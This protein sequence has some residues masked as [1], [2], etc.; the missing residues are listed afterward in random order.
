MNAEIKQCRNCVSAYDKLVDF[1]NGGEVEEMPD[2]IAFCIK[3][4]VKVPVEWDGCEDGFEAIVVEPASRQKEWKE[5]SLAGYVNHVFKPDG[6]VFCAKRRVKIPAEWDGCEDGFE[7]IEAKETSGTDH[8]QTACRVLRELKD[9]IY[10]QRANDMSE[11]EFVE[12]LYQKITSF[13][14][15]SLTTD[16][17]QIC[18][19]LA[20][21]NQELEARVKDLDQS[22]TVAHEANH[23]LRIDNQYLKST[24]NTLYTKIGELEAEF[25]A[26]DQENDERLQELDNL[27]ADYASLK[28][29]LRRYAKLNGEYRLLKDSESMRESDEV[30]LPLDSRWE[31]LSDIF[32]LLQFNID[33]NKKPIDGQ[34]DNFYVQGQKA[35][36]RRKIEIASDY[37]DLS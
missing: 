26:L 29:A 19:D 22:I 18:A 2:G 15:G 17:D 10:C 37:V 7:A 27:Q 13:E 35:I 23:R 25:T 8:P 32:Q 3:R 6:L 36:V 12:H 30:Y 16:Q 4:S 28:V 1:S 9:D 11:I 5:W 20:K 34:V 24:Y 21:R 31:K 14:E 33:Y